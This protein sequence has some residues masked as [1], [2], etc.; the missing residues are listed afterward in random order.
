MLP[1]AASFHRISLGGDNRPA[2]AASAAEGTLSTLQSLVREQGKFAWVLKVDDPPAAAGDGGGD[3]GGREWAAFQQLLADLGPSAF[4]H[5]DMLLLRLNLTSAL[6]PCADASAS[7]SSEAGAASGV[8]AAARS[9]RRLAALVALVVGAGFRVYWRRPFP[10]AAAVPGPASRALWEAVRAAHGAAAASAVE[11]SEANLRRLQAE[12][13]TIYDPPPPSPPL[14][15]GADAEQAELDAWL[16]GPAYPWERAAPPASG[17]RPLAAHPG[18]VLSAFDV[19]L[20]RE[21]ALPQ[22]GNVDMRRAREDCGGVIDGE[23]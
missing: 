9:Q 19:A 3:G 23:L 8:A 18:H 21:L 14:P 11:A 13:D 22:G 7:C 15:G 1:V 4:R 10:Q 17:W 5:H 12:H 16:A 2:G 20:V 6:L